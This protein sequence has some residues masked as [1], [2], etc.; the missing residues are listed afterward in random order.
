MKWKSE[1]GIDGEKLEDKGSEDMKT[2]KGLHQRGLISSKP[3]LYINS[4]EVPLGY[5]V[6]CLRMDG[7][8]R[9]SAVFVHE[10]VGYSAVRALI[11]IHSLHLE[12]HGPCRLILQNRGTLPVLL[13]L[14][15]GHF[16]YFTHTCYHLRTLF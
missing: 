11:S 12:H 1:K 3:Q 2:I 9:H 6:T 10:A 4:S 16:G 5:W 15:E 8:G 14:G 13:A 7:E